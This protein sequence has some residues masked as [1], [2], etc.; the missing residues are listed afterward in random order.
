[1]EE[2]RTEERERER[3]KEEVRAGSRFATGDEEEL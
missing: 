1:M 3:T 2:K